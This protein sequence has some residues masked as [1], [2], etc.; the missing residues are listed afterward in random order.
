M[1]EICGEMEFLGLNAL[2]DG[3]FAVLLMGAGAGKN[4]WRELYTEN[5]DPLAFGEL[6]PARDRVQHLLR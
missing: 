1:E 6:K 5:R 4:G 3:S 2:R